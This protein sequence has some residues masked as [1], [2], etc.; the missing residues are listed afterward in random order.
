MNGANN[1][2]GTTTTNSIDPA[3][4]VVRQQHSS[5]IE[6]LGVDN[7]LNRFYNRRIVKQLTISDN[8]A[9][10]ATYKPNL[11]RSGKPVILVTRRHSAV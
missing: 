10:R 9:R 3:L 11:A 8:T 5:K 1:D 7:A 4:N 6:F 2:G